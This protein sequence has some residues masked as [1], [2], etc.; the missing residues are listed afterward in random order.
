MS[1]RQ[2]TKRYHCIRHSVTNYEGT[3]I[4]NTQIVLFC[5]LG[6][7]YQT[8][9]LVNFIRRYFKQTPNGNPLNVVSGWLGSKHQ[10]TNYVVSGWLGS[11][12]QLTNYVV[13]G[14]LSSKHQLTNYVV[15]GCLSSKHQLTNYVISG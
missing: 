4:I 5:Q 8:S 15:S 14:C 12:H 6:V 9:S 2:Q 11:K 7:S 10:L 1:E 3:E 13:S